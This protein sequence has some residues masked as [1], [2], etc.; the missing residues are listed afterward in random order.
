MESA[1]SRTSPLLP[2]VAPPDTAL[3]CCPT[4][5]SADGSLSGRSVSPPAG[6]SGRPHPAQPLDICKQEGQV[7]KLRHLF[8]HFPTNKAN[9][10]KFSSGFTQKLHN[11][12]CRFFFI[13]SASS[14][15]LWACC[16]SL[17]SVFIWDFMLSTSDCAWNV[18]QYVGKCD[19]SMS[20][21]GGLISSLV[22]S[23][24]NL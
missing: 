21:K 16:S 11:L 4:A 6:P 19:S 24:R 1:L 20:E 3:P 14:S 15:L 2:S 10:W 17:N 8:P 5:A 22:W 9:R 18:C 23:D 7:Y 13:P 12:S